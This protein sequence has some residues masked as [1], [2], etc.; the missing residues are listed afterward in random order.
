MVNNHHTKGILCSYENLSLGRGIGLH[1]AAQHIS[2]AL[3]ID[4]KLR[5]CEEKQVIL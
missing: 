5:E 4:T 2:W 1:V 3:H